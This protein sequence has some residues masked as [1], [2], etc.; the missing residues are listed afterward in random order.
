MAK[1]AGGSSFAT[2]GTMNWRRLFIFAVPA[3][4]WAVLL[5]GCDTPAAEQPNIP[6][7]ASEDV[8]LIP[9]GGYTRL[10]P[11][12]V[13]G[14]EITPES[15]FRFM[16]LEFSGK[17]TGTMWSAFP[18]EETLWELDGE[19]IGVA[20]MGERLAKA[21]PEW[22]DVDVEEEGKLARVNVHLAESF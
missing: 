13:P 20:D 10:G 22:F 18:T 6:E 5:A 19:S 17:P 7:I 2:G 1:V 12:R 8:A 4:L 15:E 14:G 16:V 21:P 3:L 9:V 11:L